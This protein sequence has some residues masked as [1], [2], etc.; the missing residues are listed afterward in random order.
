MLPAAGAV[1]QPTAAGIDDVAMDVY[2]C[3]DTAD[4]FIA[5]Q[6]YNDLS[7]MAGVA[8]VRP[9]VDDGS[10]LLTLSC[11]P[12]ASSERIWDPTPELVAGSTPVATSD[13]VVE[14][15]PT[16]SHKFRLWL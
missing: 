12:D 11:I 16:P 10:A 6:L 14:P 9:A 8:C 3:A 13:L 7:L 15:E 1:R 5:D 2:R 4:G